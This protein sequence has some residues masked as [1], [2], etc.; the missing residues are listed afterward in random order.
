[1]VPES[2]CWAQIR[3]RLAAQKGRSHRAIPILPVLAFDHAESEH[4]VQ[5]DAQTRFGDSGLVGEPAQGS[6]AGCQMLKE[7]DLICDKQQVRRPEPTAKLKNRVRRNL[8]RSPNLL[9]CHGVSC[10]FWADSRPHAL[11]E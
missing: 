11:R 4:G 5:E 9:F 10:P 6:R 3:R 2:V 1:M 7:A 8:T